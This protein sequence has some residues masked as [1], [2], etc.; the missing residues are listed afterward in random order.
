M[1]RFPFVLALAIIVFGAMTATAATLLEIDGGTVSEVEV[2]GEFEQEEGE[3][4]V[5]SYAP[6]GLEGDYDPMP[7]PIDQEPVPS[8]TLAPTQHVDPP[9]STPEPTPTSAPEPMPSPEPASVPAVTPT[10]APEQTPSPEPT[11]TPEVAP[12]PAP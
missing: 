7:A 9:T 1:I 11:P 12:T 2:P 6:T 8:P 4:G 10:P 5:P 3:G